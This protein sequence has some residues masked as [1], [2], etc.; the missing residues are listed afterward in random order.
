MF[1]QVLFFFCPFAHTN[2]WDS[3]GVRGARGGHQA[4]AWDLRCS[5]PTPARPH[6]LL[7]L[8]KRKQERTERSKAGRPF[9]CEGPLKVRWNAHCSNPGRGNRRGAKRAFLSSAAQSRSN[10]CNPPA[11]L[12]GERN[13]GSG[14]A[15]G[16]SYRGG[17]STMWQGAQ[18]G[19]PTWLVYEPHRER[20]STGA[21]ESPNSPGARCRT[22][23]IGLCDKHRSSWNRSD[24]NRAN[25]DI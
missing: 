2:D 5:G 25:H 4:G 23:H 10:R 17:A 16:D 15:E 19:V 13:A 8:E 24:T 12:R 7:L 18:V 1:V 9:N 6:L 3:W 11:L 14:S 22:G 21:R 20:S